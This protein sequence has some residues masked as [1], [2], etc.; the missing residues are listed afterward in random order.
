L[1]RPI[2][3]SGR[4][5]RLDALLLGGSATAAEQRGNAIKEGLSAARFSAMLGWQ[6]LLGAGRLGGD[7]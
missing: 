1:R 3:W 2:N 6:R 7:M 5:R 4:S